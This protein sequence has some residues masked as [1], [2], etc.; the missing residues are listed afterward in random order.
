MATRRPFRR[1]LPTLLALP[2]AAAM[3]VPASASAASSSSGMTLTGQVL[4]G[5]VGTRA[6]VSVVA[7]PPGSQADHMAVGQ[8]MQWTPIATGVSSSNGAYSLTFSRTALLPYENPDGTVNL[9]A[10][11]AVA[12][13]FSLYRIVVKMNRGARA[14]TANGMHLWPAPTKAGFPAIASYLARPQ[15]AAVT[16]VPTFTCTGLQLK[17]IYNPQ[18]GRRPARLPSQSQAASLSSSPT[19]AV[20]VRASGL[21]S[22]RADG[23]RPARTP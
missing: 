15:G 12:H 3:F 18:C 1:V 13:K 19:T 4:Q 7:Q 20:R 9:G 23:P 2:L 22:P 11:A 10:L 5:T 14:P 6:V 16:H 8:T 17:Q 21:R